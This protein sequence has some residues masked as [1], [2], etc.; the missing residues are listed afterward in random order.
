MNIKQSTTDLSASSLEQNAPNPFSS[1]SVINYSLP[2]AHSSA[3]IIITDKSGRV[4]KEVNISGSTKGSLQME[5]SDLSAGTY[6]YSLYV[7]QKLISS[8]QM[9][10]SK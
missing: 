8:R 3:K 10:V 7:N 6:Q 4:L 5:A 2:D 9:I 1:T